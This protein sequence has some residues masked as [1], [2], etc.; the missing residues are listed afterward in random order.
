MGGGDVVVKTG[1]KRSK[2]GSADEGLGLGEGLWDYICGCGWL[3]IDI[4]TSKP[5]L[6][7]NAVMES[8]R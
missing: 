3:D 6:L 8:L 1:A 4:E 5:P 2:G 7:K